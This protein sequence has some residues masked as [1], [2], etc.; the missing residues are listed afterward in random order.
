MMTPTPRSRTEDLLIQD[1][2]GEVVLYDEA[3]DEAHLLNPTTA[4]VWKHSDG[5]TSVAELAA[6]LAQ[7]LDVPA[8]EALVE[9]ALGELSE[10]GLLVTPLETHGLTRRDALRKMVAAGAFA[11]A[12]MPAVTSI[13]APTPA[14]ASS[15]NG[16]EDCERDHG[17][18]WD[19][20]GGNRG[21]GKDYDG[22]FDNFWDWFRKWF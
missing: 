19:H 15:P 1:V 7:E 13:T 17:G 3:S 8:D 10:A 12:L 14:M 16:H 9:S 4:L 2:D 18:D 6:R 5:E 21:N 11:A 20:H 22:W